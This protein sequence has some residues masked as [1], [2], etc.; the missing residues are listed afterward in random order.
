[1]SRSD[2]YAVATL[3]KFL[4]KCGYVQC[5]L[6]VDSEPSTL[7]VQEKVIAKRGQKTLPRVSPKESKGS[8]GLAEGANGHAFLSSGLYKHTFSSLHHARATA[9]R[10]LERPHA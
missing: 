1:M 6:K 9:C 4:D 5:A 3:T 7:E 10:M 8:L 2:E